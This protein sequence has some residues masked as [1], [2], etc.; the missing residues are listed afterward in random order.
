M[1]LKRVVTV[2]RVFRKLPNDE[3]N[4]RRP[5]GKGPDPSRQQ[6]SRLLRSSHNASQFANCPERH[7][8]LRP[9][10][11]ENS[12][13]TVLTT[14][15]PVR[16]APM[17]WSNTHD[18]RRRWLSFESPD[19][20]PLDAETSPP[21]APQPATPHQAFESLSRDRLMRRLL[22][23]RLWKHVLLCLTFCGAPALLCL[24]LLLTTHDQHSTS[25]HTTSQHTNGHHTNGQHT[26]SLQTPWLPPGPLWALTGLELF[27]SAQL[28]LLIATVRSAS[29]IDFHGS[30]RSWRWL[31]GFLCGL[32]LLTLS[33]SASATTGTLAWIL[34]PL[35]G[36]LQSARPALLIVPAASLLLVI[37]RIVVP[38]MRH[39]RWAQGLLLCSALFSLFCV[40]LSTRLTDSHATLLSALSLTT[41]GFLLSAVLLHTRFVVH[42]NPNPPDAS[43]SS[44]F[45][46]AACAPQ[47]SSLNNIAPVVAA[48]H[49]AATDVAAIS[50]VAVVPTGSNVTTDHPPLSA[51]AHAEVECSVPLRPDKSNTPSD[52]ENSL[53]APT[54]AAR[55]SKPSAKRTRK[56]A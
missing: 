12:Q 3:S 31:S 16:V 48:T 34:F 33:H 15:L 51:T 32:A 53:P 8:L 47:P 5:P 36:P 35:T 30:Y 11:R 19:P 27:T 42:V 54:T 37:L 9:P 10:V 4:G 40:L 22:S 2:F 49:V 44:A 13:P 52:T 24:V 41:S 25:Q 18:R 26:T 6:I 21:A 45:K 20:R 17:M 23:N 56:S 1:C 7:H 14:L 50:V 39:S 28:C 29:C 55:P 46:S 43:G 38:D